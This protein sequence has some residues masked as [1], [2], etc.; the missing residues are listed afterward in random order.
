MSLS[1]DRSILCLL[2]H[3]LKIHLNIILPSTP[4]S[5]KW[6]LSLRFPPPKPLCTSP[7]PRT[8]YLS[9]P[10]HSLFDHPN[11]VWCAVQIMKLLIM[12]FSPLPCC[13]VPLRPRYLPQ[14]PV[15][16]HHETTLL[17]QWSSSRPVQNKRQ[18]YTSV[19]LHL[20]GDSHKIMRDGSKLQRWMPWGDPREYQ[21]KK[22][23][24]M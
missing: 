6:Y 9:F 3:Y 11:N 4:S 8:C 19:Y 2:S 22:E 14:H 5:S 24:E 18:N 23:L 1:W 12:Y 7:L 20:Y 15:L 10:S 21:E 16:E 17:P 13:L